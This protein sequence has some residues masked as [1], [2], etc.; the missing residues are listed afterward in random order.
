MG[1]IKKII[2][3]DSL[4]LVIRM[5]F[6][7]STPPLEILPV[8]YSILQD[9]LDKMPVNI[10]GKSG[11]LDHPGK[12]HDSVE[13]LPNYFD[14]VKEE[15]DIMMIQALYRAYC[16]LASAYTLE[17]SFQHFRKTGNY[18]KRKNI[19]P[20]Q[21]AQPFV[22]VATKLDVYPW[23]DYHYAY[24]LEI[25]KKSINLVIINGII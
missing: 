2:L 9:I 22:E 20:K 12:I 11:Y 23:L 6:Y 7:L 8:R 18:E 3:T 1:F 25:L 4:I 14:N 16:F 19:L 24:S 15:S 5:G 17:P 21:I 13:G 10:N